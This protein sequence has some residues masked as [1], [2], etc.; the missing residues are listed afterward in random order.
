ME[1]QNL[2]PGD[3]DFILLTTKSKRESSSRPLF[4]FEDE[5]YLCEEF[6]IK[7]YESKGYSAFFSENA[8]WNKLIK[9]LLKDIFKE[10]KKISK[11]KNYKS[12]FYN[13]E[14]FEI[15]ED[16]INERFNYLKNTNLL[17]V[18]ENQRIKKKIKDKIIK[19]CQYLHQDQ[20]LLV[21][22]NWIQNYSKKSKGFPDLFVFNKD[23]CFFCEV[24][25]PADFL[26]PNQI[27]N[28]EMLIDSGIDVKVFGVNKPQ[29]WINEEKVK[30]FNEDFYDEFSFKETYDFK[31]KIA[32]RVYDE[33]KNENIEET[34]NYMLAHYDLDTFLGFLNVLNNYSFEEKIEFLNMLD[35][36]IITKSN[37]EGLKIH[38]LRYLSKGYYFEVRGW[39]DK[40]I[41]EYKHVK[42]YFGC[43]KLCIC[44]RKLKDFES[45][46][47]LTYDVINNVSFIEEE[48]KVNFKKRAH[49]F[50]KNKNAISVY[51]TNN[52]CPICGEEEVIVVLHKRGELQIKICMNG[53]CYWY[54]GLYNG[55]LAGLMEIHELGNMQ[56]DKN[57]KN[58]KFA[59]IR[60]EKFRKNKLKYKLEL[61]KEHDY[62]FD[63]NKSFEENVEIKYDL[64]LHGDKLIKNKQY[65]EAIE[66][67]NELLSNEL[68]INDY[69][70]YLKLSKIY[71]EK[72]DIESEIEIITNFFK[73]DIFARKSTIAHFEKR[74]YDLDYLQINQLM[75]YYKN[76]GAKNRKLSEIPVPS[77]S[78]IKQGRK[79]KIKPLKYSPQDFDS[80]VSFNQNLTNEEKIEFKKE[81]IIKG[82][83]YIKNKEYD[84]AIAFFTRLLT[85]RLFINDYYQYNRLSYVYKKE[86]RINYKRRIIYKK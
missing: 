62:Q 6:V 3:L 40:A 13:N 21:L 58:S 75:D 81:L 57:L 19:F 67:F 34:R 30:Y 53:S 71:N 70:P 36:N 78:Y 59:E 18:I 32:N 82:E 77:A 2:N 51:K 45:E 22:Y 84:K 76:H 12:G 26:S 63:N 83:S 48:C 8:P 64:T 72:S 27:R 44:Y 50:I 28:H 5:Y 14:F 42:N 31:I 61:K 74:L 46:V 69:Y 43:N 20:I 86:K 16:K 7:Y 35:E 54:G 79:Y 25:S 23:N 85:H 17:D 56:I 52:K 4:L 65:D 49:R 80:I 33:L 68:F 39:Y 37:H 29:Y 11:Q 47:N 73:S 55:S 38:N 60:K 41:D 9:V 15:C 66:F 1:F 10:F 24:K